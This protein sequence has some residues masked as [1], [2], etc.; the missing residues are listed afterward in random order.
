MKN[1]RQWRYFIISLLL[2]STAFTISCTRDEVTT[3]QTEVALQ[4]QIADAQQWFEQQMYTNNYLLNENGIQL[5]AD[6]RPDWGKA[7]IHE[8]S[9][10]Y[11]VEVPILF[12]NQ[13]TLIS[14][15]LR[16]EY[17]RTG[18]SK[19]LAAKVSLVIETNLTTGK[20]QDFIML[21]S[22]SLKYVE[23]NSEGQN[24]YLN[25]DPNFD[26]MVLYYTPNWGFANGWGFS[27]GKV[28]SQ[29]TNSNPQTRYWGECPYGHTIEFL[30][31]ESG[32]GEHI[33]MYT[34][35]ICLESPLGSFPHDNG[36][37]SGGPGN[38]NGNN[39]NDQD[40]AGNVLPIPVYYPPS[41]PDPNIDSEEHD[42]PP[43]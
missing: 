5:Y 15:Q 31:I 22:P 16:A 27:D 9:T 19:Y 37:P 34:Y 38:S 42:L 23:S 18:N 30:M 33:A 40:P 26:G 24:S 3:T 13:S 39:M 10:G 17:E 8:L 11:T 14:S 4:P 20:K 28:D 21:V 7:A 41:H 2:V 6:W 25:M 36:D 29:T 32:T 1:V 12:T 35:H 43:S